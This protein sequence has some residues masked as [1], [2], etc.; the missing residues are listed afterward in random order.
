ML[1]MQRIQFIIDDNSYFPEF[2]LG[3]RSS[4]TIGAPHHEV[5]SN[6][7]SVLTNYIQQSLS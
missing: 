7:N 6:R 4:C 2:Y 3:M 1:M 5:Q